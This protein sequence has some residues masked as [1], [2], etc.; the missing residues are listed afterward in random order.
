MQ[1]TNCQFLTLVL[2]LFL[3]VSHILCTII[4]DPVGLTESSLKIP[5]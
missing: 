5:L 2:D 3:V 1:D 4:H